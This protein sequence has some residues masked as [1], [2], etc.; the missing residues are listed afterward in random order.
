MTITSGQ[1]KY[2]TE[3]NFVQRNARDSHEEADRWI[4]PCEKLCPHLRGPNPVLQFVDG[5]SFF[6]NSVKNLGLNKVLDKYFFEIA[7]R[8]QSCLEAPFKTKIT[9][10]AMK[11]SCQRRLECPR[12][13]QQQTSFP[14][15]ISFSRRSMAQ[16][17]NT[18]C[19][20]IVH[21][22]NMHSRK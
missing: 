3:A 2:T 12:I 21:S 16:A 8:I 6:V 20:V 9:L 11:G 15:S 7:G 13:T 18:L 17:K 19:E 1:I 14:G 4:C 22:R 5:F 10:K